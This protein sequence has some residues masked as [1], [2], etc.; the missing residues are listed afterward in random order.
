MNDIDELLTFLNARLNE[1]EAALKK[2][3]SNKASYGEEMEGGWEL[4][5]EFGRLIDAVANFN[6]M[7]ADIAAKWEIIALHAD[8]GKS[9]GYADGG[10]FVVHEHACTECGAFGEFGEPWPCETLFLLATPYD[11]HEDYRESWRRVD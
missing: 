10:E 3:L 5:G 6:E 2:I 4:R 11:G 8:G 9:Q 7:L 1:R